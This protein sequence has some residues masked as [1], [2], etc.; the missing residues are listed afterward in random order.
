[1]QL[2][3]QPSSSSMH[4]PSGSSAIPGSSVMHSSSIPSSAAIV[5]SSVMRSSTLPSV[6]PIPPLPPPPVNYNSVVRPWSPPAHLP[7]SFNV[8][9][10]TGAVVPAP[11]PTEPAPSSWTAPSR[12]LGGNGVTPSPFGN[13]SPTPGRSH[14]SFAPV[15]A[16]VPGSQDP[17]SP[18]RSVANQNFWQLVV[19]IH[20]EDVSSSQHIP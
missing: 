20:T 19:C 14:G 3:A 2:P 16:A 6:P 4:Q 7:S 1:M 5:G 11:H 8:Q 17:R 10:A 12:R 18:N 9:Q 15:T 13:P